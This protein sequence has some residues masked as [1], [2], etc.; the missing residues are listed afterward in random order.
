MR[1]VPMVEQAQQQRILQVGQ[2]VQKT[3]PRLVSPQHVTTIQ[4]NPMPRMR[5][6]RPRMATAVQ[7]TPRMVTQTTMRVSILTLIDSWGQL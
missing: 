4:T 6:T 2:T 3:V 7:Q 1:T 5:A